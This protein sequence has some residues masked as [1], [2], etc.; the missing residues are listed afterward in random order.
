[1]KKKYFSP[2]VEV[3]KFQY[4]NQVVADSSCNIEYVNTNGGIASTETCTDGWIAH[5]YY[6]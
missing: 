3:V 5:K 6:D 1:M 2:T 4:S